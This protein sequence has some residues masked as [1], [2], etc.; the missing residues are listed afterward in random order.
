MSTPWKSVYP[1]SPR[2]AADLRLH[3]IFSCCKWDPQIED[4]SALA[5]FAMVLK[6]SAFDELAALAE[7]LAAETLEMEQELRRRPDLWREMG[8][9]RALR[10]ALAG[11]AAGRGTGAA[12]V[13]RFDF[14]HTTDGWRISEVNSDVPGGF[15]EAAGLARFAASRIGGVEAPPDPA[16]VIADLFRDRLGSG[17][18]VA[19][20][21][22]SAYTDD[23]QV[24]EFVSRAFRN[25]GLGTVSVAPDQLI[26]REEGA[27]LAGSGE[28]V[29]GIF[30]FYP[31]E[32]LPALNRS[33]RWERYF[34]GGPLLCNPAT[35]L[36]SQ[37][38]RS[39]A[40]WHEL[41]AALPVWK[42]LL[43]ETRDPRRVDLDSDEWLL[44]PS[45]GRVGEAIGWRGGVPEKQWR[46]IRRS[47]RWFPR[48]WI[49]QRRFQ[50]IPMETPDGPRHL[51][52]GVY[53]VEGRF[54]GIYG[55]CA[56]RPLVNYLAQDCA[57]LV[58]ADRLEPREGAMQPISELSHA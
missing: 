28:P 29:H 48:D 4:Q 21:H 18:R 56:A 55:R 23:F 37:A 19:F 52:L 22:A 53:T 20:V 36:L 54:A 44:K 8:L 9:P 1:F 45:L 31:G 13:M 35:A 58:E 33:T 11:A 15:I 3:A 2:E 27:S 17:A 49:A 46:A 51:C 47:A 57:V 40:V 34:S 16:A 50:S 12:R 10:R 5:P 25:R 6:G 42:E 38:K 32:W 7:V 39:A 43:P 41:E 30:R 14:H 24:V 26:W